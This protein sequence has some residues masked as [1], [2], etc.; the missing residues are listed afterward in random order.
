M[1]GRVSIMPLSVL[2]RDVQFDL[3]LVLS[4]EL[5]NPFSAEELNIGGWRNEYRS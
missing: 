2:D 5:D 4:N 3:I 1:V